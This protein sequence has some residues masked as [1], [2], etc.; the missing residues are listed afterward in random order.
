MLYP[1][2]SKHV[3]TLFSLKETGSKLDLITWLQSKMPLQIKQRWQCPK[4]I[5]HFDC[6]IAHP[7]FETVLWMPRC[8]RAHG[9]IWDRLGRAGL[10]SSFNAFICV[11]K[12]W[13]IQLL[14][15]W[16]SKEA[17]HWAMACYMESGSSN[18]A[19]NGLLH[20]VLKQQLGE[21]WLATWSPE[22][23]TGEQQCGQNAA[24]W[25]WLKLGNLTTSHLSSWTYIGFL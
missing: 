12:A 16:I 22:A 21:Q 14:A 9:A 17:T 15:T 23:A 20:G 24:A 8:A 3:L 7:H 13:H 10:C 19:S 4:I 6:F 1:S 5:L 18:S 25:W 2:R 11:I